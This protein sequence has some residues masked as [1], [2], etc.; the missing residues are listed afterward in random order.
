M[1][2][3]FLVE[4]ENQLAQTIQKS[5][6]LESDRSGLEKTKIKI[7][8]KLKISNNNPRKSILGSGF[9]YQNKRISLSLFTLNEHYTINNIKTYGRTTF[10]V[11][12]IYN[13]YY[14]F[15]ALNGRFR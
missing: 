5:D 8:E 11:V 2:V 9:L 14:A 10:I 15:T 13:M 3:I 6:Q 1:T 12:I 7:S 4:I